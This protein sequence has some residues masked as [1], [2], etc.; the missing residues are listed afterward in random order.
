[1]IGEMKQITCAKV[2]YNHGVIIIGSIVL[3]SI[4]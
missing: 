1:M 4:R 3:K 2:L